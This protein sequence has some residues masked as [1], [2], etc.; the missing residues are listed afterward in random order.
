MESKFDE[1]QKKF[2]HTDQTVEFQRKIGEQRKTKTEERMRKVTDPLILK[3][4][5][6]DQ[7]I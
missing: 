6:V 5:N 2:N 4:P 1:K 3:K 7:E